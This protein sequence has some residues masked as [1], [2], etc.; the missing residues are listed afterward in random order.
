MLRS[1]FNLHCVRF[2][3][4]PR[5]IELCIDLTSVVQSKCAGVTLFCTYVWEW[6]DRKMSCHSYS[7]Q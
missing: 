6:D 3:K 4:D 7:V 5:G 2:N 1:H